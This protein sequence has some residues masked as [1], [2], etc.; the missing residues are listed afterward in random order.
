MVL[1]SCFASASSAWSAASVRFGVVEIVP[2]A[3]S[4]DTDHALSIDGFPEAGFC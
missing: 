1:H 3:S 2:F 4:Y